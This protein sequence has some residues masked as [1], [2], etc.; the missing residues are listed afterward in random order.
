M[1]TNEALVHFNTDSFNSDNVG[2]SVLVTPK[3][4]ERCTDKPCLN[5]GICHDSTTTKTYTCMCW[6]G[7]VGRNCELI[8]LDGG[9]TNWSPW[10]SCVANC[11]LQERNRSCTNPAPQNGGYDCYGASR[12]IRLCGDPIYCKDFAYACDF[13]T[14]NNMTSCDMYGNESSETHWEMNYGRTLTPN[15]GPET[16]HSTMDEKDAYIYIESSNGKAFDP[17]ILWLPD[18]AWEGQDYCMQFFYSMYGSDM[19]SLSIVANGLHDENIT[20]NHTSVF[21][22]RSGDQGPGWLQGYV[23]VQMVQDMKVGFLGVQGTGFE[24]DIALD[25]INMTPG[26]C[27]NVPHS[28]G[29]YDANSGLVYQHGNI[30]IEDGC[31][32]RFCFC[33]TDG[34]LSCPYWDQINVCN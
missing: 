27:K 24:S 33:N 15:T 10:S 12:E 16:G 17:A 1:G 11:S 34:Q 32:R 26:P 2:F 7:T 8:S 14:K 25:D 9:Y 19:G 23:D 30:K 18:R 28:E 6:P 20:S 22:Q 21:W 13:G 31:I 4:A 5:G 29:C 3:K